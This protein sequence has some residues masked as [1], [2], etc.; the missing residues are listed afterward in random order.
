M[1]FAN[2]LGWVIEKSGLGRDLFAQKV[3]IGRRQLFYYLDGKNTPRHDFYQNLKE[4]FDWVDLNW[5]IAGEGDSGGQGVVSQ[6]SCLP[7]KFVLSMTLTVTFDSKNSCYAIKINKVKND[8]EFTRLES[9]SSMS[10]D[11]VGAVFKNKLMFDSEENE[12]VSYLN[13]VGE[14]VKLSSF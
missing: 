5:L 13:A 2:R 8:E 12:S 11:M 1:D 7:G 10:L 4:T 9:L 3:G 14:N 6:E